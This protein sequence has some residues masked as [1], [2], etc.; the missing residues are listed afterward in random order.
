MQNYKPSPSN[1]VILFNLEGLTA[2]P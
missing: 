1:A 2:I